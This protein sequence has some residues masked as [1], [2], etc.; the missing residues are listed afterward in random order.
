MQQRA[1]RAGI[2]LLQAGDDL[3]D[4]RRRGLELRLRCLL[5]RRFRGSG[6]ESPL[7]RAVF[8]AVVFCA[9]VFVR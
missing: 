6:L 8:V 9:V 7:P 1:G 4:A 5:R 2:G 3:R